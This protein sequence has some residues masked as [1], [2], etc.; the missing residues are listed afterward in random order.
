MTPMPEGPTHKR[1]WLVPAIGGAVLLALTL[2]ALIRE[3]VTLDSESPEGTVQT[4]LQAISDE[5]FETAHGQL[6]ADLR[7]ECTTADIAVEGPY[8][9][10]T[11]TLGDVED[12]GE[13]TLVHVSIRTG[14]EAGF[15]S[16]GYAFEPGPYS[17]ELEDGAWVITDVTWPYFYYACSP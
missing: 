9:A 10:F 2:I 16:T 13:R 8:E 12:L 1:N 15:G 3:P 4:F 7:D 11:A 17:L 5:D 6:S 14:T